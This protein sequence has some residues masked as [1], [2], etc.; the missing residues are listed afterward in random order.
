MLVSPRCPDCG[1]HGIHCDPACVIWLC[2]S[3]SLEGKRFEI[4][5]DEAA[6]YAREHRARLEQLEGFVK[7][8]YTPV[9][10]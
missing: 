3:C 8:R 5:Y 4:S 10:R 7:R 6:P 9:P 1:A 2:R